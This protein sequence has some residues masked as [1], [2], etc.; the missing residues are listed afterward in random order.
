MS[1]DSCDQHYNVCHVSCVRSNS[2]V[3]N[4]SSLQSGA[5]HTQQSRRGES[6]YQP[7][8]HIYKLDEIQSRSKWAFE[9]DA[10]SMALF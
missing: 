9:S 6:H 3:S 10:R 5:Q 1:S 7:F 8:K 2:S 4:V